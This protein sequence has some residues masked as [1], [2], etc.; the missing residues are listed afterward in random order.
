MLREQ[1]KH[2]LWS[3]YIAIG[4]IFIW[5]GIWEG[6]YEIP[7]VNAW[8]LLFLGLTML[9]FSGLIFKEFDPLGGIEK[10]THN[11]LHFVHNHPL[12]QN[13]QIHYYDKL[14]KKE[15]TFP[16]NF[17]KHLEKDTLIIQDQNNQELFIPLHRITEI[18]EKGKTYWK[19]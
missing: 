18:K 7:Y 17:I 5:R 4:V 14:L 11:L 6:V 12:K 9:T 16:A 13:F 19:L 10:S 1:D 8:T 15:L 2:F 3:L